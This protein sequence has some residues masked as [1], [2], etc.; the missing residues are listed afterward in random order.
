M[1]LGLKS[2]IVGLAFVAASLFTL[3][4]IA[5]A[6]DGSTQ[7]A[8]VGATTVPTTSELAPVA[9]GATAARSTAAKSTATAQGLAFTGGDVA[10][11]VLIG[12]VAV[13]AGAG[14]L[15]VRRRAAS[16]LA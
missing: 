1:R 3:S 11:L 12:G 8:Y 7:G 13:I 5:G 4:G 9:L 14:F 10:G 2:A 15:A 6:Q 16:P